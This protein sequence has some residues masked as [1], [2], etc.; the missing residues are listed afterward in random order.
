MEISRRSLLAVAGVATAAGGG[1][2]VGS[3]GGDGEDVDLSGHE[4]AVSP[5]FHTDDGTGYEGV[6][7]DGKPIL[8]SSDADVEMYYWMDFQC[9]F[10]ERFE[11]QTFP[12]LYRDHVETG[13]VRMV[14]TTVPFFGE[15]SMTA[16]VASSCVW[17]EVRG[18][19]VSKY[20]NWHTAVMSQ[21]GDRNSGW[22]SADSLTA[23]T[24]AVSGIDAGRVED[25]LASERGERA[26]V[27]RSQ[28]E[29]ARS[30]GVRA[31]PGFVIHNR[32]TGRST[33]L[34][35]AQPLELFE[36]GIDEVS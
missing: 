19:D 6:A 13:D 33:S 8:G 4:P 22:A 31:T 32:D 10:C 5:S 15:D 23:I 25:C 27:V 9:P 26:E 16:A 1:Y 7:F 12:D 29:K 14:L 3:G 20:W 30:L 28:A 11:R 34:S 2:L 17:D 24:E 21:Q 35:G 18:G 36:R